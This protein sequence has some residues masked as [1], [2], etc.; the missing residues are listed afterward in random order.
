MLT[1]GVVIG[2]T[3]VVVVV[4]FTAAVDWILDSFN[5]NDIQE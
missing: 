3:V 2:L 1:I 4:A 5:D